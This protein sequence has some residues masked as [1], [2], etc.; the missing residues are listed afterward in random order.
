[1]ILNKN[2]SRAMPLSL[3]MVNTKRH[4]RITSIFSMFQNAFKGNVTINTCM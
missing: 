4:K 2:Y 1:M 3:F